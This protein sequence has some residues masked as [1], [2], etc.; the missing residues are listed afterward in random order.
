MIPFFRFPDPPVRTPDSAGKA[1]D[2][3]EAH[4]W[5]RFAWI[6]V[7]FGCFSCRGHVNENQYQ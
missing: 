7:L 4:G 1:E 3:Q 2:L 5:T 6:A